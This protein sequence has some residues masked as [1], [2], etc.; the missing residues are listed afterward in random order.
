MNDSIA[1]NTITLIL[2]LKQRKRIPIPSIC[3]VHD[4]IET[5]TV[6]YMRIGGIAMAQED[7]NKAKPQLRHFSVC[8]FC[9]SCYSVLWNWMRLFTIQWIWAHMHTIHTTLTI[10]EK[11]P[12]LCHFRQMMHESHTHTKKL[13]P[14]QMKGRWIVE[15]NRRPTLLLRETTV[16]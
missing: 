10:P 6:E 3:N 13:Q 12:L 4:G 16:D 7:C 1:Q 5:L 2:H 9:T 15:N 14:E 8:V 11:S